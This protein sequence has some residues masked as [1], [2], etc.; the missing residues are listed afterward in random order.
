MATSPA[1]KAPRVNNEVRN[2]ARQKNREE[3]KFGNK[4]PKAKALTARA[5]RRAA[6]NYKPVNPA[7]SLD[8]APQGRFA[9]EG[10]TV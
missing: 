9:R 1:N 6:G 4:G 10:G 2:A 5:I 3:S 8:Q 7:A